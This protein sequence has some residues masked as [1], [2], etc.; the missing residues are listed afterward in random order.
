MGKP[1]YPW[2]NSTIVPLL[3][4]STTPFIQYLLF[5]CFGVP[6]HS[7]KLSRFTLGPEWL[8]F[9]FP[10]FLGDQRSKKWRSKEAKNYKSREAGK[11]RKANIIEAKKQRSREPDIQKTNRTEKKHH[12]QKCHCYPL[13]LC[14]NDNDPQGMSTEV[15]HLKLLRGGAVFALAT[16]LDHGRFMALAMIRQHLQPALEGGQAR[17]ISRCVRHCK[18]T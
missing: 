3:T 11:S 17:S 16:G 4:T 6:F 2:T 13:V 8:C 15:C 18:T 7:P 9:C 10:F 1:T 5:G 12:S 14:K